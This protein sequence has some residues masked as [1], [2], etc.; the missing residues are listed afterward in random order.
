MAAATQG[1]VTG[2]ISSNDSASSSGGATGADGAGG[3]SGGSTDG[4]TNSDPCAGA[5]LL[6]ETFE[7]TAEGAIPADWSYNWGA[8]ADSISVQSG[9][10]VSGS[11]S[12][13]VDGEAPSS[14]ANQVLVAAADFGPFHWGRV[15]YKVERVGTLASSDAGA[16]AHSTFL[17]F[18]DGSSEF[19]VFDTVMNQQKKHQFLYNIQPSGESEWGCGS[20]YDF[21]Y[22]SEWECVEWFVSATEQSYRFFLDGTEVDSIAVADGM[23]DGCGT[24][25]RSIPANLGELSLGLY[26]YQ[27]MTEGFIVWFD[28]LAI[29]TSRLGC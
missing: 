27:M 4:T 19:R 16:V 10:S 11:R 2:A 26:T 3:S 23:T 20:A 24:P 12:L 7:S 6:C 21:T 14:G 9:Q 25:N 18:W 17:A 29:G 13:R 1:T 8:S 28:D 22:P 15:R 5:D